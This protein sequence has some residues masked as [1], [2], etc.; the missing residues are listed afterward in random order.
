MLGAH[1]ALVLLRPIRGAMRTRQH[2]FD[3]RMARLAGI[4]GFHIIMTR[5][6]RSHV[7]QKREARLFGFF[8]AVVARCALGVL[9]FNMLLVAEDDILT[10][11]LRKRFGVVA[12][13]VAILAIFRVFAFDLLMTCRA[14][15]MF[16]KEKVVRAFAG[17]RR[18]VTRAALRAEFG[19]MLLMRKLYLRPLRGRIIPRGRA[20][21]LRVGKIDEQQ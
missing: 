2:G 6:A 7:G 12:I 15:G 9:L 13:H 5:V 18:G 10:R 21:A 19:H 17:L 16:G 1:E 20:C 4:R 8:N 14:F 11:G 3:T